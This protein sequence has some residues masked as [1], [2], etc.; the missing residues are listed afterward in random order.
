MC[1]ELD[2]DFIIRINDFYSAKLTEQ[3]EYAQLKY[4]ND[5]YYVVDS[6]GKKSQTPDMV[7]C[8]NSKMTETSKSAKW[9]LVA[10]KRELSREIMV[11]RYSTR[12]WFE[13]GVKDLKSKLHWEKYMVAELSRST[14][15]I[16][17]NERLEK[18]I[19][20]SCLSYAIQ[21]AIGNQLDMSASDRK[22]TSIF[23]KFRQTIRRGTMELKRVI[24]NF[25]N[26]IPVYI[27][28]G[29]LCFN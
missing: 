6:L 29:R 11:E 26:I 15:K 27:A 20:I 9:Y 24:L 19:I 2:L 13:E 23:N 10:N 5:G 25:I 8:V 14:E 17:K 4:F 21:T 7:L 12:F 18:C 3:Q 28:R 22:R 16:P 1:K